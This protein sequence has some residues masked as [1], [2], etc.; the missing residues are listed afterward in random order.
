MKI[1]Y[2]T[3]TTLLGRN[4]EKP[5]TTEITKVP[6][7]MYKVHERISKYFDKRGSLAR[8]ALRND[9]T[10]VRPFIA[11]MQCANFTLPQAIFIKRSDNILELL[12]K[13]KF[14]HT[15]DYTFP[16]RGA[17]E[18]LLGLSTDYQ[19]T[20]LYNS[21]YNIEI[22][23]VPDTRWSHAV[24]ANQILKDLNV[25]PEHALVIFTTILQRLLQT[26]VKRVTTTK[27]NS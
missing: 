9:M 18:T 4:K 5:V 10:V 26:Y 14:T 2:S 7:F 27:E 23:T 16:P 22:Y 25:P 11:A 6:N 21:E 19:I 3:L 8:F 24:A 13:L 1:N 17:V 15:C 20:R 12:H